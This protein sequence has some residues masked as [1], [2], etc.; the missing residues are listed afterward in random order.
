MLFNPKKGGLERGPLA[1][2]RVQNMAHALL[3]THASIHDLVR[4]VG[5]HID[6]QLESS[7]AE[8]RLRQDYK[9]TAM[10]HRGTTILRLDFILAKSK[11][12]IIL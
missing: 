12:L 4:L 11:P 1:E 10:L 9:Q 6:S 3:P 7:R 2:R 8:R 5:H